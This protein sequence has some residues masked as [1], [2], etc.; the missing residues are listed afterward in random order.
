MICKKRF[1]P[2]TFIQDSLLHLQ[3]SGERMWEQ[4]FKDVVYERE[5]ERL[6]LDTIYN[7]KVISHWALAIVDV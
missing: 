4:I 7:W 2:F 3:L 6:L 1:I 5:R